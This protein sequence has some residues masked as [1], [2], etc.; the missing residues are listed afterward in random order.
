MKNDENELVPFFFLP[1]F[2]ENVSRRFSRAVRTP[3]DT[4]P[5]PS[6]YAGTATEFNLVYGFNESISLMREL[7]GAL[8]SLLG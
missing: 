5:K 8:R 7:R 6:G 2:R 3:R 4:P 1:R